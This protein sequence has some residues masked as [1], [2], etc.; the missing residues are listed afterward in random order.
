[1]TS[2]FAPA[3]TPRRR[4]GYL[5][6]CRTLGELQAL[7]HQLSVNLGGGGD[8]IA[9]ATLHD[10]VS[11]S[12]EETSLAWL[13]RALR[14]RVPLTQEELAE[15]SGLSVGTVRGLESG[16][17]RRPHSGSV[18]GL[19]GAL[20]LT[21]PDRATLVAAARGQ[22]PDDGRHRDQTSG[23]NGAP[24]TTTSFRSI[25]RD[26]ELAEL[27]QALADV[28][29]GRGRTVL[30]V[31][32]PGIGKT[33]L[34]GDAAR[35]ARDQG[36]QV[37][38]VRCPGNEGTP[39]YWPWSEAL[40]LCGRSPTSEADEG[41]LAG[42][43]L[44][45]FLPDVAIPASSSAS[46]GDDSL[47]LEFFNRVVTVFHAAARRSPLAI[48]FDD[49]HRA[50]APSLRLF[51]LLASTVPTAPLLLVGTYRD[52]DGGAD[53]PVARLAAGLPGD[54]SRI[55]LRP[56]AVEA[57]GQLIAGT[58]GTEP[59]PALVRWVHRHTGGNPLF[60]QEVV[61]LLA[62]E[63][64]LDRPPRELVLPSGVRGV[65]ERRLHG[66]DPATTDVLRW[67][68]ICG[69]D[70]PQRLLERASGLSRDEI[71]T[72]L[73]VARRT[74]LI[75]PLHG[76]PNWHTFTHGLVAEALRDMTLPADLARRH[77]RLGEILIQDDDQP[78]RVAEISHHLFA[79]L[80]EGDI[81][82]ASEYAVRAAR[83]AAEALA[84]EE[85]TRHYDHAIEA[86][87][88]AAGTEPRVAELL[89]ERADVAGRTGYG[90]EAR[91]AALEAVEAARRHGSPAPLGAGC[92]RL[93]GPNLC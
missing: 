14:E 26:L 15:R 81:G 86:L 39:P 49:L 77:H 53:Q 6:S 11:L 30:V 55:E 35:S 5:S 80:P 46:A 60:A 90:P 62:A 31:G 3:T 36:A 48:V 88:L 51:E 41:D 66:F 25:G 20:G 16:R 10:A 9:M 44:H 19:I 57:L 29:A 67:A 27:R 42:G 28:A 1:M 7:D 75:R 70:F 40:R 76:R 23:S 63:G 38:V 83:L 64:R 13:V 72:A 56:L 32:E 68:A 87:R 52:T 24:R 93:L 45:P 74:R 58:S 21:D 17:I 50:D 91:Q 82:F 65:I 54:A 33:L 18:R 47:R 61:R 69:D 22:L 2:T 8:G 71:S 4:L 34:I 85:A 92:A 84:W 37:I 73:A 12:G 79:A 89:V 78:S 59:A 43:E